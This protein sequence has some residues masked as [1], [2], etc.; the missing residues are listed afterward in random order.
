MW[1][2][3]YPYNQKLLGLALGA[4][5]NPKFYLI[6]KKKIQN[7]RKTTKNPKC[8]FLIYLVFFGIFSFLK[9]NLKFKILFSMRSAINMSI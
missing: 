1:L 3:Y 2:F 5:H 9:K 6:L 8:I 4:C 7:Y